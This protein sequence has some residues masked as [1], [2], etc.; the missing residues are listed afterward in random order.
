M[1]KTIRVAMRVTQIHEC[2]CEVD[3]TEQ[4]YEDYCN[5]VADPADFLTDEDVEKVYQESG[6]FDLDFQEEYTEILWDDHMV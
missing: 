4:Q 2:W 6:Q 3:V 1:S 5:N